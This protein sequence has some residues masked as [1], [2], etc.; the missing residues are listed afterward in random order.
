[1]RWPT[2]RPRAGPYPSSCPRL[3]PNT[4]PATRGSATTRCRRR[5]TA[6]GYHASSQTFLPYWP[7]KRHGH[8]AP[9]RVDL[10]A[11]RHAAAGRLHRRRWRRTRWPASSPPTGACPRC[12]TPAPVFVGRRPD[13]GHRPG[14]ALR[15]DRDDAALFHRRQRRLRP[16]GTQWRPT[17]P[18]RPGWTNWRARPATPPSSPP[19]PTSTSPRSAT[20]ASTPTSAPPTRWETRKRPRSCRARSAR[21]RHR[22]RRW[23]QPGPPTAPPTPGC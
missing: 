12:S 17:R 23:R 15:R 4:S 19:T 8:A 9:D 11:D 16:T 3:S 14:A 21:P 20:A 13:L 1:M 5:R 6:S 2:A 22:R 18:P 7:I 10:A